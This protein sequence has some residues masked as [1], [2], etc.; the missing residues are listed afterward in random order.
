MIILVRSDREG[1]TQMMKRVVLVVAPHLEVNN[2][3]NSTL[4]SWKRL[5]NLIVKKAQF[6]MVILVNQTTVE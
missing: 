4:K 2:K 3:F 5:I 6:S 1:G